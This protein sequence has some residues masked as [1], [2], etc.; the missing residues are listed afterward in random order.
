M[1][2]DEESKASATV[3]YVLLRIRQ[4]SVE[5]VAVGRLTPLAAETLLLNLYTGISAA[6]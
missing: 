1:L 4:M 2:F 6:Y 3:V 5:L